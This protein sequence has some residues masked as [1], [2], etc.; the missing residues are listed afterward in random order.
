MNCNIESSVSSESCRM[1]VIIVYILL[2]PFCPFTLT[3]QNI[4]CPLYV[5]YDNIPSSQGNAKLK[6]VS[7]EMQL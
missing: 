5:I 1:V 2:A 3:Y 4:V 7:S 6:W